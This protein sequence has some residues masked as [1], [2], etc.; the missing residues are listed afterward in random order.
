MKQ[1]I[2]TGSVLSAGA[3]LLVYFGGV[4][5]AIVAIFC[6]CLCLS[7]EFKALTAAGHRPIA[8]PT[9]LAMGVS[10][11]LALIV[12]AKVV[13]PILLGA[14]V[15]I[16][17]CVLFR[18]EPRLEDALM[19]V[20]PLYSIVLP[21]LCLV[22]ISQVEPLSVQRV[23]IALLIAVPIAGDTMA[24]FVGSAVGGP[25][26]CP[27]VSP[28]KTWSGA[29]AG[30]VGSALAAVI[31]RLG[32]SWMCAP[33]TVLPTWLACL[34]IGL[35]G[36]VAGQI[37]DLFASLIKRHCEIKDFSNIFPGHGGMMDRLDSILF[38][39]LVLFA[40]RLLWFG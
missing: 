24:Y 9:W 13:I 6:F 8:G 7:E 14:S 35:L 22:S 4:T 21:G 30:L 31:I 36:G 17:S 26:M 10:I 2:I 37:G 27:Q 5:F 15:M 16:V 1:R 19:S 38:M 33:T 28:K 40:Y 20:L 12:G 25:K 3:V 34:M 32:A 18:D 39:S 23:M 29:A 11:P